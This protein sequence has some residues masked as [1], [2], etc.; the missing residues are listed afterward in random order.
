MKSSYVIRTASFAAALVLSGT[1]AAETNEAEA[2]NA[3][4]Q[5]VAE[6][7]HASRLD[8]VRFVD[9]AGR[10]SYEYWINSHVTPA[11]RSYCRTRRGEVSQILSFDGHWTG[12]HPARPR[13]AQTASSS[14]L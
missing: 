3:C 7:S 2:I 14:A 12:T 10:G 11:K 1:T 4:A 6:A 9:H 8:V 13:A 5:A